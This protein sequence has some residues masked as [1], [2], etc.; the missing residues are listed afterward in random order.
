MTQ[1]DF[2]SLMLTSHIFLFY[3]TTTTIV[4][5][6]CFSCWERERESFLFCFDYLLRHIYDNGP[7]HHWRS[8]VVA[9]NL[10]LSSSL[11]YNVWRIWETVTKWDLMS[12]EWIGKPQKSKDLTI[13]KSKSYFEPKWTIFDQWG[14][15]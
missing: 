5:L 4:H 9:S 2:L 7:Q 14:L 15:N 11:M 8:D 6:R 10:I 1:G 12:I 3:S 13:M